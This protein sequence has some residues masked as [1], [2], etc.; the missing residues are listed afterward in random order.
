M[1]SKKLVAAEVA[2]GGIDW[3]A[4]KG[5]LFVV[6]PLAVE[7]GIKTKFSKPGETKDA[8]RANVFVLIGKDKH[9]AFEDTLIFPGYLQAATRRKIGSY[10]VGRLTQGEDDSKG[11]PPW[12]FA[13]PTP[14]DMKKASEFVASRL[15][16]DDEDED[17]DDRADEQDEDED[18]Y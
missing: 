17:D 5:K 15:V 10:V 18:A 3:K 12:L 13:E 9:E 14:A 2:S 11:N 6:E 1:A 8:V 16:A 4:Y 7:K